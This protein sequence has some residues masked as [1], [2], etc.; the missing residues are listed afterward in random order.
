MVN[1]MSD[2]G[3]GHRGTCGR[4]IPGG[5]GNNRRSRPSNR[6]DDEDSLSS[7]LERY[8]SRRDRLEEEFRSHHRRAEERPHSSRRRSEEYPRSDRRK[9]ERSS[10][11]SREPGESSQSNRR[12]S[13]PDEPVQPIQPGA[14][15]NQPVPTVR[16]AAPPNPPAPIQLTSDHAGSSTATDREADPKFR[17]VIEEDGED[18]VSEG[19]GTVGSTES[20][21]LRARD[22]PAEEVESAL[23]WR[24]N[25]LEGRMNGVSVEDEDMA[26]AEGEPAGE[27]EVVEN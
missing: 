12:S 14:A 13:H 8:Q 4:A 16:P 25:V 5:N 22:T 17:D 10:R 20:A 6:S 3:G 21:F 1:P 24:M 2:S 19:T 7:S 11:A 15:I 23:G 26:D 18:S 9:S 27:V